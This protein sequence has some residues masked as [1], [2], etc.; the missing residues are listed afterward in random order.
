[1]AAVK[2]MGREHGPYWA[3]RGDLELIRVGAAAADGNLDKEK[4]AVR[5]VLSAPI[6]PIS[7]DDK[8]F[9]LGRGRS[10][11][12]AGFDHCVQ[13]PQRR[14]AVCTGASQ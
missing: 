6:V 10:A 13:H 11:L 7:P 4:L 2:S 9:V 12:A 8:K 1:M 3:R 5:V 14:A